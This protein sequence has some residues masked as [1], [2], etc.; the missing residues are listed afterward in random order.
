MEE[1][2]LWKQDTLLSSVATDI[3]TWR[4][5]ARL[6][7]AE[8]SRRFGIPSRTIEDWEAGRRSPADWAEKLIVDK[9]LRLAEAAV[10]QEMKAVADHL[11]SDE[12]G[13]RPVG[14]WATLSTNGADEFV[15]YYDDMTA[16]LNA[17]YPGD[18]V[19]YLL[20]NQK[21]NGTIEAWYEDRKGNI[22]GDFEEVKWEVG[23]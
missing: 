3:K 21:E 1:I 15:H 16:A 7:Q 5:N 18:K 12:N 13:N 4:K 23:S 6:S 9:L 11:K 20:C 2:R 10:E 17:A 8:M 19:V 22:Y 14:T